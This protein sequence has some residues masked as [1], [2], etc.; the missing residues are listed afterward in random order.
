MPTANEAVGSIISLDKLFEEK[1]HNHVVSDDD[2]ALSRTTKNLSLSVT[3]PTEQS[4]L[5]SNDEFESIHLT[6]EPIDA[7]PAKLLPSYSDTRQDDDV[8]FQPLTGK[9]YDNHV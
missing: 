8:D 4:K 9:P 3:S 7:S 1:S 2:T 6:Q 5:D